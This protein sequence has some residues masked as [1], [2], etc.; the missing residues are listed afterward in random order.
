MNVTNV[1]LIDVG[2]P[3][4]EI[5]EPIGIETISPYIECIPNVK[6]TLESIELSNKLVNT[7]WKLFDII[8]ISTKIRAFDR[9]ELLINDIIKINPNA[10]IILGDIV[11]TFGY[12]ELLKRWKNI[13]CVIGEGEICMPLLVR[14][15]RD[16]TLNKCINEIPNIA[17]CSEN[18]II[19]TKRQIVDVS[20]ALR[21]TRHFIK[22]IYAKQGIVHLE[23][24]RGCVY[25]N[26]SFC[27]IQQK[28]GGV[29]WRPFSLTH[30]ISEL[31]YLSNMGFRSPYFTDE[32]F[33]GND[34]ERVTQF[35]KNLINEKAKGNINPN[36][37]FYF[38]ARVDSILGTEFGD[39]DEAT[40]VLQLL[41]NA[42]LREI[43]IGVES[44][45][46]AQIDRYKK[47][48]TIEKNI[49]AINLLTSLGI[50]LDIGFIFFDPHASIDDLY[51][52]L[53]FIRLAQINKNYSRL[54][55]KLRLQP[56]TGISH[57]YFKNYNQKP[58]IN[59]N[60]VCFD[61]DF[62]DDNVRNIYRL[63]KNWELEDLDIIYNMQSFCRG[64]I[65]TELERNEVKQII[66]SYRFLDLE[67]LHSLVF[68]IK[69]NIA[70]DKYLT[71]IYDQF[72]RIREHIDSFNIDKIKWF[73][74]EYRK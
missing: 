29:G 23:G 37:D 8:G 20:K 55:K 70:T 45:G 54:T 11:S 42:G 43:F 25:S 63:F 57:G 51:F 12:P 10:L 36:L 13:I 28:Y 19:T 5:S 58:E 60:F 59:L 46:V 71:N 4:D 18:K 1:I 65:N 44:G 7:N 17:Y 39:F 67:Y 34:V 53:E 38:N 52:N 14:A 47:R 33:Y 74:N 27:G 6:L 61:Y 66:S 69:E 3:R 21:P 56:F 16:C 22:D 72:H 48:I 49:R 9:L 32:D 35:C 2:T 64:E 30:I 24:S 50:D 40:K 15:Y 41:K 62:Q 73:H 31:D 26:C 68:G